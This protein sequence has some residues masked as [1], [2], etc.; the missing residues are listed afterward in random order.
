[1]FPL[2][3]L[4]LLPLDE[5]LDESL[6]LLDWLQP[7]FTAPR[8]YFLTKLRFQVLWL[9]SLIAATLRLLASVSVRVVLSRTSLRSKV[10]GLSLG[11]DTTRLS[12]SNGAH[13]E[14]LEEAHG[15]D[16]HEDDEDEVPSC[17]PKY[18]LWCYGKEVL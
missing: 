17:C 1:M 4:L 10:L 9:C 7:E 12:V 18:L 14:V 2:A 5:L 3:V 13:Q 11:L 15:E 8:S 6:D 16:A